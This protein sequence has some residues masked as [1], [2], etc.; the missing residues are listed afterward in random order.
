MSD[1]FRTI[2]CDKCNVRISAKSFDR[3]VGSRKCRERQ[4]VNEAESM[5][6]SPLS[7]DLVR[8]LRQPWFEG[9]VRITNDLAKV[10]VSLKHH[11]IQFNQWWVE[12]WFGQYFV[13]LYKIVR[14]KAVVMNMMYEPI[15][16]TDDREMR[17]AILEMILTR[18]KDMYASHK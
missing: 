10:G 5:E 6:W 9:R 16:R 13:S 7:H 3:H 15:F 14:D 11:P 8:I 2:V 12:A 18:V 1:N 17:I 4:A